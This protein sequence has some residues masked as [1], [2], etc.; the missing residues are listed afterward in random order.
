MSDRGPDTSCKEC[1]KQADGCTCLD[2]LNA[3]KLALSQIRRQEDHQ[4]PSEVSLLVAAAI[5]KADAERPTF[6]TPAFLRDAIRNALTGPVHGSLPQIIERHVR[7]FL[8][9]RFSAAMFDEEHQESIGRLWK[10]IFP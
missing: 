5:R 3:C 6:G 1:K 9:Q 2:L 4:P 10:D 8:A 7:D